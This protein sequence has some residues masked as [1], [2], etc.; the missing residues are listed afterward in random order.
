MSSD[1][2]SRTNAAA[3][4]QNEKGITENQQKSTST[5][6]TES[7][8]SSSVQHPSTGAPPAPPPPPPLPLVNE[9]D[10]RKRNM[11]KGGNQSQTASRSTVEIVED[12][13]GDGKKKPA[14]KR[15]PSTKTPTMQ[16]QITMILDRLAEQ[17]ERTDDLYTLVRPDRQRSDA[18]EGRDNRES[19][20]RDD[21]SV[22]SARYPHHSHRPVA[23]SHYKKRSPRDGR[24]RRR[25][26]SPRQP[27]RH[28]SRRYDTM[29]SRDSSSSAQSDIDDQVDRALHLM[30]PRF[31][32]YKG[33]NREADSV[34]RYRPFAYLEREKQRAII[35]TGHPEELNF[36]QHLTGL[37]AMAAEYL[38]E[39]SQ[40]HGIL[41]HAMQIIDDY[42]H[43]KWSNIRG[44]SNTVVANVARGKWAWYDHSAIERC[45]TNHYMRRSQHDDNVWSVPCPRYNRGRC[46]EQDTHAV[47]EVIMRHTCSHCAING[48]ENPHTVRACNRRK[49]GPGAQYHKATGDDKKDHR[50]GKSGTGRVDTYSEN[51]KN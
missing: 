33:R 22:S 47:G 19:R 26:P 8:S 10:K 4:K 27:Q 38:D 48:Y 31:S 16:A 2:N 44:F 41:T 5:L 21:G 6:Q 50:T 24:S 28:T 13:D 49:T 29:S 35:K 14:K 40:E 20:Y 12:P 7:S 11:P 43:V 42:E 9:E 23:S 45:R 15:N 34:I 37:C 39:K 1:E 25:R 51:A 18:R 3:E 36:L 32:R 30:E 46:D 17:A